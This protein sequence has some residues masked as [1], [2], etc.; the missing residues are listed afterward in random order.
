MESAHG[1]PK[2]THGLH[3]RLKASNN[4]HFFGRRQEKVGVITLNPVYV[5]L[6]PGQIYHIPIVI[7][8]NM[9]FVGIHESI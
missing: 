2:I 5:P 3:L 4:L 6:K 7:M 8:G 9:P 1:D